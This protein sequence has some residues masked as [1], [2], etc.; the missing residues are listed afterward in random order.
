MN[1]NLLTSHTLL[2]ICL[3]AYIT[4]ITLPVPSI[5]LTFHV[6]VKV[7][8]AK[9]PF[10]EKSMNKINPKALWDS[11]KQY[12][13]CLSRLWKLLSLPI[14][15]L[16]FFRCHIWSK[17]HSHFSSG[18]L[19]GTDKILI[20]HFSKNIYLKHQFPFHL[21]TKLLTLRSCRLCHA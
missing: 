13:I 8:L 2:N 17:S 1:Y 9:S 4:V 21:W 20:L 6:K 5:K 3:A 14:S 15:F 18:A 11:A 16:S 7:Q 12:F 10:W 19:R